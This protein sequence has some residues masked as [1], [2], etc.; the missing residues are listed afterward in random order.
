MSKKYKTCRLLVGCAF[1]AM[2]SLASASNKYLVIPVVTKMVTT[3]CTAPDEV[4]SAG[5]RCW[6]DRNLGASQVATSPGNFSAFGDYYQWGRPRDGHQHRTS[7]ITSTISNYDDP[8]HNDFIIEL[9]IFHPDWRNPKNDNLWQGLGGINNP[10]P[11]GFRLPTAV[12]WE[13]EIA[14]WDSYDIAGAF[15]S[16]LK[17]VVA[18]QRSAID[19]SINFQTTRG[20]YWS[21]TVYNLDSYSRYVYFDFD[22]AAVE[23][24]TRLSGMSVRC[25]KD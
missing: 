19:G 20:Y 6:K 7:G 24:N 25:I 23:A 18:G 10:C 12:E 17:L 9:V 1:I 16:P 13:T 21:S 15:S 11:Q 2:Q 3:T 4:I 5:D 8:E 22:D 14:S